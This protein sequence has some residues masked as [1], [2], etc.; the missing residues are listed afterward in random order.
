[1]KIFHWVLGIKS[2]EGNISVGMCCDDFFLKHALQP[3][4]EQYIGTF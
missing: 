3:I 2:H 4:V 1:M